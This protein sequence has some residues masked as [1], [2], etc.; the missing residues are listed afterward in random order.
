M[1]HKTLFRIAS[2]G[3]FIAALTLINYTSISYELNYKSYL[4]ITISIILWFI[5]NF[6][7]GIKNPKKSIAFLN[8]LTYILFAFIVVNI[9]FI[10]KNP[11]NIKFYGWIFVS[12]CFIF[13]YSLIIKKLKRDGK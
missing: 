1:K 11:H 12:A 9:I 7:L 4:I 2:I 13:A 5:P 8:I 6:N 10:F 3:L